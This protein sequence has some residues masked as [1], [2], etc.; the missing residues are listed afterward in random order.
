MSQE[1][2]SSNPSGQSQGA[3]VRY[4]VHNKTGDVAG[5]R[6]S[7]IRE[8]SGRMWQL[9]NDAAAYKGTEKLDED[10]IVKPGESIEFHRRQGEK[11]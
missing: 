2:Q 5:K 4:G 7:E 9:P 6:I 1:A 8:E 3:R 11:G 10:Y